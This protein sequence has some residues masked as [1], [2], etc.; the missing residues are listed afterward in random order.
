MKL[1]QEDISFAKEFIRAAISEKI[2]SNRDSETGY[3]LD[4]SYL[5]PILYNV[6]FPFLV[7]L[8]A[9][10]AY[11]KINDL[12]D[13]KVGSSERNIESLIRIEIDLNH[14]LNPVCM[15]QIMKELIPLGFTEKEIMKIYDTI[16]SH[17]SERVINLSSN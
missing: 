2:C 13:Q 5:D 6:I 3:G 1:S 7:S 4:T 11:D 8:A 16:K 10:F 9:S 17:I 14:P 12:K 15:D